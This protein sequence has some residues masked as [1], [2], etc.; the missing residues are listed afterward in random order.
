MRFNS[1]FIALLVA[2]GLVAQSLWIPAKALLAEQLIR[3]SWQHF[4]Q[5]GQVKPPW[6]WA[7]T[8]AL[9]QMTFHRLDRELIVLNGGDPTTLAFSVGAVA[10]FNQMTSSQPFVVA[11]HNDSHFS[12]LSEVKMKDIITLADANGR[13]QLYQ[14]EAIE[15]IDVSQQSLVHEEL[16]LGLVLITCYPFNSTATG[17]NE[18]Y[19]IKAKR[20]GDQEQV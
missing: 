1:R 7:D 5:T 10:P 2:I 9:V 12:F 14:V 13:S 6:P 3:K 15:I 11:G 16:E 18:R 17:G 8:Q 20:L 19:I 4:K